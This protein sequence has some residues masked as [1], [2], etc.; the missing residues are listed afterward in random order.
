MGQC[1][2]VD[3]PPCQPLPPCGNSDTEEVKVEASRPHMDALLLRQLDG[4][5]DGSSDEM[6]D[7]GDD[8][9]DEDVNKE[10]E[11]D[12]F[13]KDDDEEDDDNHSLPGDD[14]NDEPLNSA[15]DV[16]DEEDMQKTFD[17]DNVV[18]C[19]YDKITRVRNKW[20]FSLKDGIMCLNNKD[21]VFLKATGEGEW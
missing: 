15:D 16:S 19:Q 13:N 3:D 11:D 10:D 17:T 8:D 4:A 20:K 6:S 9:D 21:Y 2:A 1:S 18:V 5:L 7:F 12:Q 14:A